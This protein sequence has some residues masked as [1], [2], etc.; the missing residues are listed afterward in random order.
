MILDGL[1]KRDWTIFISF[2][3][4]YYLCIYRIYSKINVFCWCSLQQ[5]C[6]ALEIRNSHYGEKFTQN[7]VD[8]RDI[9]A[10]LQMLLMQK[11]RPMYLPENNC[12]LD[13]CI[14]S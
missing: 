13:S 5:K 12:A 11:G 7:E 2:H 6:D 4:F 14:E 10:Y 3:N 8:R 9:L 1:Q